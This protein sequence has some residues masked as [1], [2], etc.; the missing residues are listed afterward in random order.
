VWLAQSR[1]AFG[2][3]LLGVL[4]ASMGTHT[5]NRV[6]ILLLVGLGIGVTSTLLI[7]SAFDYV[8]ARGLSFRPDIWAAYLFRAMNN[9]IFGEGLLSDRTTFVYAPPLIGSVPDAHSAYIGTIRDGGIVGLSLLGGAFLAALWCGIRSVT[10]SSCYLSLALALVVIAYLATDTDRLITRTGAQWI[11]LW[12]P[13]ALIMSSP[14]CLRG[15]KTANPD[16]PPATSTSP[17]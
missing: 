15:R 17:P 9:P 6:M 11:F 13:M 4:V 14:E 7:P 8:F 12:L 10:R 2:A 1:T 3:V 5:R 16:E